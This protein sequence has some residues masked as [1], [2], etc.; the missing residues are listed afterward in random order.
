M[1]YLETIDDPL[2]YYFKERI[3]NLYI[4]KDVMKLFIDKGNKGEGESV[5]MLTDSFL[6]F[7][8]IQELDQGNKKETPRA[9][10][11]RSFKKKMNARKTDADNYD[12]AQIKKRVDAMLVDKVSKLTQ[13]NSDVN[14]E[15]SKFG[16]FINND[17]LI[18]GSLDIQTSAL[19]SKLFA[20]KQKSVI[21]GKLTR[22]VEDFRH[23]HFWQLYKHRN[24]EDQMY[25]H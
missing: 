14:Q 6:Q 19:N 2:K 22:H 20:R 5:Q 25:E 24:I 18:K 23:Q 9:I 16:R 21:R 10:D 11:R 15:G 7:S 13:K 1:D 3:G 17:S 12:N 4:N 8:D